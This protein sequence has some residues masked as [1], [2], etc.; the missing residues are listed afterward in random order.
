MRKFLVPVA[1]IAAIALLAPMPAQA[2]ML[3]G[4]RKEVTELLNQQFQEKP[5]AAGLVSSQ[6][7]ELFVSAAGSW[8]ILLTRPDGVSCVMSGGTDWT[9]RPVIAAKIAE[10]AI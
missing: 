2:Q 7:I 3:C 8:T 1:A 4:P 5:K 9:E 6:M 10:E